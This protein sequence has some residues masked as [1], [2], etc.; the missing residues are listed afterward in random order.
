MQQVP[1]PPVA[2]CDGGSGLLSALELAGPE[3]KVKRG[4]VQLHQGCGGHS[5]SGYLLPSSG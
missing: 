5:G 1:A 3:A 2:V 4:L